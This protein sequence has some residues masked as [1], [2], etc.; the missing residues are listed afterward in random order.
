MRIEDLGIS[1]KSMEA[2]L[3]C[4]SKPQGM[5]LVTGPTGSGKSSTLYACLNRLNNPTVNIITVEDPVEYDIHGI[6]QVQI[7]P[8]AGITFAAGL[9]SI[10]RQDPDIVMVGEIRD[11][12]TASIA[13]QAAQ[14]GHLVLSTLHTNDA[15]STITRL[16]DL[17]IE[18]FLISTSLVAV[19]GQRL[20]RKIC[21]GCKVP[22][23]LSQQI[24]KRLPPLIGGKKDLA[25][26]KGAGCE[27][28]GYS[29]YSG[30]FGLFE[31]LVMTTTLKEALGTKVTA[32][33]LR[34]IAEGEGFQSM[35][36]DGITKAL[37]GMTTIEELFRVAP[38]EI[39]E[40]P[41]E[42]VI[43]PAFQEEVVYEE[44]P[45]EEHV[46]SLSMSRPPKILLA[47]D[48]EIILKVISNIL[49]SDGYRIDRAKNGMEAL[50][51][52]LQEKPDLIITDFL[53]PVMDGV[54][55]IKRLKSQLA[56]RYIPIIM[57]TAK[58]EEDAEVEVIDAGADDYLTKPVNAEKL[59]VRI[60]RL[61]KRPII[62]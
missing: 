54:T 12:E 46:S 49:E 32:E 43:Q 20:V 33:G 53:M 47:D 16:M 1:G 40:P 35:S 48:N 5:I 51:L 3:D 24:M 22:D 17:G 58:D 62:E 25:F 57:L 60:K 36:M 11:H 61:L 28:C 41:V 15:P 31:V 42:E 18:P 30:R 13:C 10:L 50:R 45:P 27:A 2:F 7:N 34:K 59:L 52:A 23:P 44:S 4:L 19:I 38:P 14:T 39:Y 29:G 26:S 37:Q 55:L 56:T 8:T 6:N 9:R 21:P